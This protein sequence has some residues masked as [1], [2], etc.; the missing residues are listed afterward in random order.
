MHK[1]LAPVFPIFLVI[2]PYEQKGRTERMIK[3]V[4]E[5]IGRA[6]CFKQA[7]KAEKVEYSDVL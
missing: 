3:A 1:H 2:M 7:K 6:A 4:E 5:E